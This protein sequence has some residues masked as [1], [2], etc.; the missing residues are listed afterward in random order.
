MESINEQAGEHGVLIGPDLKVLESP[1]PQTK[2]K[3]RHFTLDQCEQAACAFGLVLCSKRDPSGNNVSVKEA[4]RRQIAFHLEFGS[5][6]E[7]LSLI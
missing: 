5:N 4:A 7:L 6:E 2:F 3:L 1:C